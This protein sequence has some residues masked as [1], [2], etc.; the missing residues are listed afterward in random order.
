MFA[1]PAIVIAL[2]APSLAQASIDLGVLSFNTLIP[3]APNSPG[4]NDFEIDNFTGASDLPPDFPVSGPLTFDNSSLLLTFQ[5]GSRQTV[6]LGDLAPGSYTPASLQF[7]ATMAF[8]S[9]LFKA[10]LSQTGLSLYDG[11]STQASSAQISINLVPS[12]GAYSLIAVNVGTAAVPE[13]NPAILELLALIASAF[14]GRPFL[15]AG[16][17][18]SRPPGQAK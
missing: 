7:S 11:S 18:S 9:A 12:A 5:G 16:R 4:L 8:T 1:K 10:T 17:L 15:A 6:L 3:G 14:V 13:P 2:L